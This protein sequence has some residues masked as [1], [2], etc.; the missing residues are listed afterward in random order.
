MVARSSKLEIKNLF[1]TGVEGFE[2]EI[3]ICLGEYTDPIYYSCRIMFTHIH[4]CPFMLLIHAHPDSLMFLHLHLYL[5]S[6][7]SIH[8]HPLIHSSTHSFSQP[9]IHALIYYSTH[10]CS[11]SCIHSH[12]L[13]IMHV[14][15]CSFITIRIHSHSVITHIHSCLLPPFAFDLGV[16]GPGTLVGA[17]NG[18]DRFSL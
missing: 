9:F 14:H 16:I 12:S 15:S 4:S 8:V 6:F 13:I 17:S 3:F 7:I 18:I 11:H 5:C 10:S 2:F 1:S